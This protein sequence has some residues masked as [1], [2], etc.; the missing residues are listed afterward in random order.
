MTI[1]TIHVKNF[2][3][4]KEARV[5]LG[6]FNVLIGANASGKSN[7]IH[8]I[9]FL[10]DIERH[11]LDNAISLQGGPEYLT[12]LNIGSHE[13]LSVEVI[14]SVNPHAVGPIVGG[15]PKPLRL[16]AL[17]PYEARYSLS[18]GFPKRR[19]DFEVL[20]EHLILT[21]ELVTYVEVSGGLPAPKLL[22]RGE[23]TLARNRDQVAVRGRSEVQCAGQA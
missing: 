23:M 18:L 19:T 3:S 2:K 20:D 10:R 21:G 11:G 1:K 5:D 9:E 17:Q 8:I 22:G 15:L 14:V 7:F 12:N 16:V 4:F 6:K 13:G